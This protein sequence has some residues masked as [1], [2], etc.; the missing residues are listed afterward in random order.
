MAGDPSARRVTLGEHL[1]VARYAARLTQEDLAGDTFSK[2]YISAVERGKMTPSIPALRLLAERLGVSL[3][4]LLGEEEMNPAAEPESNPESRQERQPDEDQFARRLD[5]ARQLLLH[6]DSAA[7]LERLG[8]QEAAKELSG[9]HQARWHWLYGWALLHQHQTA[10][11]IA[12]L[13]AGLQAALKSQDHRSVGL[14]YLVLADAHAA[15]HEDMTAERA[16]QEAIHTA[17]QMSD[18]HLLSHVEEQYGAFFA[19]RGR[20]Q[21]AY[22]HLRLA[23]TA[24][25]RAA[26][27]S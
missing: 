14:L 21:E 26:S 25:A 1:R 10:Q 13:E 2:S 4:Y 23:H 6:G 3:A 19:E 24:S 18:Y 16:F 8:S 7:A 12:A 5:E 15:R 17:Q 20:Y 27:D 11:A 9:A 22:E